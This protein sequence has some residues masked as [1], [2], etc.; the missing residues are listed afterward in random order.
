MA[1]FKCKMCGGSLEVSE[2][3]TVCECDYCG[4]QQTVPSADNEKKVNLFNRANR[5]RIASEFDKAAGIYESIVSEFPGEAEAYW[6]LCLCKYG[7]E[8]VDDPATAKK[9]PTCHRTSYDSIFGDS[10]YKAALDHADSVANSL[11]QRE[12]AEIDRLQKAILDIAKNEAPYDV[13][14]CYKETAEDGQRTKD[15][16]LAQDIYDAL[17]AK[18]YKVFFARIT[19]EDKL[20]QQY[21]PYIFS[22][23]NSAKVMLS[24]GTKEEYFN[25]VWVRN[26]WSRFLDLMKADRKKVLI[27]CYSDMDAYDMPDEFKNLQAQDMGKVGFIQDLV[28]G[29]GKIIPK[30]QA[31]PVQQVIQQVV[32]QSGSNIENLLKRGNLALEDK[33]WIEAKNFFEEVLN[34]DVE[35]H[36]AYIGL[37][38]AE[39]NVVNEQA[40]VKL[41]KDFTGSDYYKKACRFGGL[42]VQNRLFTLNQQGIYNMAKRILDTADTTI[43]FDQAAFIFQSLINFSDSE[44]KVQECIVKKNDILYN[45]AV[46]AMSRARSDTQFLSVKNQFDAIGNYKDSAH[47][48]EE[49]VEKA[50]EFLYKT[51]VNSMNIAR[52]DLDY[53]AVR[54][55]FEAIINYKD[56][57]RKA[58]ECKEC[59]YNMADKEMSAYHYSTAGSIFGSILDY[60]DSPPR[61]AECNKMIPFA[62]KYDSAKEAMQKEH[63]CKKFRELAD[64][65]DSIGDYRDS[66]ALADECNSRADKIEADIRKQSRKKMT[67][68]ASIIIAVIVVVGS[69]FAYKAIKNEIDRSKLYKEAVSLADKGDYDEAI[70]KF[71]RLG[72]YK[73]SVQKITETTGLKHEEIY[74]KACELAEN[75]SYDAALVKFTQLGEYKDS[76]NKALETKYNQAVRLSEQGSYD[77]AIEKFDQLGDYEDSSNKI[78]ETKYAKACNYL[79]NGDYDEA[80]NEFEALDDFSDS[81]SQAIKAKELKNQRDYDNAIELINQKQYKDAAD[82]LT[83]LDGYKDSAE[84]L[85][86]IRTKLYYIGRVVSF[87]KYEWYVIAT[88]SDG[89]TLLCKDIV[90]KRAYNTYNE[91]ITWEEC[92]LREY[93]NSTFYNTFSDEEKAMIQEVTNKNPD[94]AESNTKGGND[95]KDKIYLLSIDEAN[96]LSTDIRNAS[97]R[98]WLRSPGDISN[99]A[100][101]V[102]SDGG[103]NTRGIHVHDE[104]GVRPALNLKF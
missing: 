63:D 34:E 103:V 71:T 90:E 91:S 1:V 95:T 69:L 58:E 72:D 28:R 30:E 85:K 36:R 87:G 41:E 81:S 83:E 98:W 54:K 73:D 12:A 57:A 46:N 42:E 19:L 77:E 94:N 11:Y 100:A 39:Q 13:F 38:C 25:A 26:E 96:A 66:K 61:Y 53:L 78:F 80:I 23:L 75:G 82:L 56:S 7:I 62:E 14:I 79:E 5:L 15:S 2:G 27:P 74:L 20:G 92:T 16:V 104:N 32:T 24:I 84:Q 60:K 44:I 76:A 33:K 64:I 49:C 47:K 22:A 35:E 70:K 52:T 3:M 9:I 65:F 10:N 43:K 48:A 6:G 18:G 93:L 21:E 31:K 29:I 50:Y 17:T 37:L 67:K 68:T 88:N 4:T 89:C 8:Y 59:L 40:L 86:S 102:S 51:A 97:D 55:Q 101:E 99:Y 45:S